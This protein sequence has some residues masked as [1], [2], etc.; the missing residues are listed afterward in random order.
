MKQSIQEKL[1]LIK[2]RITTLKTSRDNYREQ[3]IS[4]SDRLATE[5][6]IKAEALAAK[7]EALQLASDALQN[8]AQQ[9]A[10][11]AAAK[12]D[13]LDAIIVAQQLNQEKADLMAKFDAL[14]QQE[15]AEDA[16]IEQ[17]LDQASANANDPGDA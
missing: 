5:S 12:Q 2:Q 7:A 16:E 9:E 3:V 17:Q 13:A 6:S 10:D 11:L 15:E 8:D 14:K 1:D 4:L